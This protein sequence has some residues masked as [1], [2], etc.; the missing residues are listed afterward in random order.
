MLTVFLVGKWKDDGDHPN[1]TFFFEHD[2]AVLTDEPTHSN[3]NIK[4]GTE[5]LVLT[6]AHE[7]AHFIL[8]HRGFRNQSHH[9]TARAYCIQPAC[10]ARASTS[11]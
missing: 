3:P 6:L 8:Q 5:R 1:G 9:T 11:S 2:V 7:I 10:R 4:I